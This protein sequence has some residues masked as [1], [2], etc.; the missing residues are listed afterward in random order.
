MKGISCG[1]SFTYG[2]GPGKDTDVLGQLKNYS[3]CLS[4]MIDCDIENLA[5]PGCSNYGITVQIRHAI[6][7]KPDFIIF[8]TTTSMRYEFVKLGKTTSNPPTLKDFSTL[9]NIDSNILCGHYSILEAMLRRR[10]EGYDMF[11]TKWNWGKYTVEQY[12]EL[13]DFL[14]NYIDI[15]VRIDQDTLMIKGA[16]QNLKESLIP[17]VCIDTVDIVEDHDIELIKLPWES[18]VKQYPISV[19]PHHWNEDGHLALA[20][21]LI[22]HIKDVNKY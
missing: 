8:N 22:D 6:E 11:E 5:F 16:I 15:N 14:T 21:Q 3:D 20:Q 12:Q 1:C 19:D 13:Y 17:F 10:N 4:E 18:Y 7:Q 2:S 9:R